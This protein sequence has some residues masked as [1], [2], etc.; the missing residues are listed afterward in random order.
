MS[1][2]ILT[3]HAPGKIILFGEHAVVYGEP[4]IGLPLSR[5]ASVK[6]TPGTGKIR[7][8]TPP[9]FSVKASKRA[10][11]PKELVERALGDAARLS[12][13]EIDLGFPPMSGLGS[14][15]A[16]AIALLRAKRRKWSNRELLEAAIEVERVAHARP[17]GVDPAI[18]LWEVPIIFRNTER[19]RQIHKLPRS[20]KAVWL[21]I[22]TA[23]AHGGTATTV[24]RLADVRTES[25]RLMRAAMATLGETARA[26][27]RGLSDHDLRIAAHAMDVAHGVLSGLGIVSDQVDDA[28]RAARNAGALGAKMSG[29]GGAGGAFVALAANEAEAGRIQKALKKAKIPAWVERL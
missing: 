23:G 28:V 10:A 3:G 19:G 18:C 14:S 4:A 13:V 7:I 2:Q 12:D 21:V 8:R 27:A 15:A 6:L 29:A 20:K 24:S 11:T 5:G 9:E 16:I 26:G 1:T 22:G 17:S 25:P